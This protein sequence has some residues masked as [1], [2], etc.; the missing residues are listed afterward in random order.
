LVIAREAIERERP[1]VAKWALNAFLLELRAQ[2]DEKVNQQAYDLL[3]AEAKQV[4]AEI[5]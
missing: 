3:T 5:I 2:K 1:C 4:L